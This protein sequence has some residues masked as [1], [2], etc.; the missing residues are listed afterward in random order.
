MS[1][2]AL[3]RQWP[4]FWLTIRQFVAGRSVRLVALLAAAPI[5]IGGIELLRVGRSVDATGITAGVFTQLTVPTILPIAALVLAT[6]SLANELSDRTMPYLAMKP[7]GRLRLL[8]EKVTASFL[9][10]MALL[11]AM[12]WVLWLMLGGAGGDASP[13]LLMAMFATIAVAV[14]AYVALFSL[15]SLV[16]TRVLLAGLIYVLLWE[17]LLARFIPGV[18]LISIRHY[19]QSTFAG[20]LDD[21][22]VSIPDQTG[23]AAALIVLAAASVLAIS[24]GWL[25]LRT[26]DL[27]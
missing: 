8:L 1:S 12:S 17:S 19:A 13:R 3:W 2:G 15:L 27:D 7:V 11:A 5:V 26:M 20:L 4:I 9:V 6:S 23:V 14:A 24:V 22:A 18:R 25:R 16:V 21:P 10:T